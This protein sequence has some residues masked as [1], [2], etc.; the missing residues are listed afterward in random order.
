MAID[1]GVD[2]V[3][4]ESNRGIVRKAFDRRLL[5]DQAVELLKAAWAEAQESAN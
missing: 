5:K 4:A 2:P 1:A 3:F